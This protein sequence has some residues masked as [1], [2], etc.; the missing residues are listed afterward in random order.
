MIWLK[1]IHASKS[2]HWGLCKAIAYINDKI[3]QFGYVRQTA[4]MS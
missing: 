3:V 4:S 1:L 2:G